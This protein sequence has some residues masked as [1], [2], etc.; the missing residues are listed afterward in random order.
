LLKELNRLLKTESGANLSLT[1]VKVYE[2]ADANGGSEYSTVDLNFLGDMFESGSKGLPAQASGEYVNV[3]LVNDIAYN[4]RLT[5][6][7]ISGGIL[8]TPVNGTQSSGVAFT[9]FRKLASYNPDPLCSAANCSRDIQENDFLEM[10]STIVHELGHFLGLNH[11]SERPDVVEDQDHDGLTDTPRCA[12]RT[13]MSEVKLDQRSCYAVDTQSQASP[14]SGQSCKTRCDSVTSPLVYWSSP[15]STTPQ[16]FCPAVPECQFNHIMWW[17]T[18]NRKKIG[19]SWVE[20]GNLFS[21]QST[22]V[23]QRSVFL[24]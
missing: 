8:G 10:A 17:T 1:D 15:F 2:W 18:K 12:A 5:V 11:P 7:G 6:L 16:S 3:F 19:S 23:L 9:T 22:A 21:P 24:R 13:E 14:L 20:D 4:S